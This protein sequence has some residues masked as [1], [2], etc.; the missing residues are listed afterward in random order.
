MNKNEIHARFECTREGRV[1]LTQQGHSPITV[2]IRDG[3]AVG[4]VVRRIDRPEHEYQCVMWEN[5]PALGIRLH[6][7]GDLHCRLTDVLVGQH[8]S[9]CTIVYSNGSIAL[10]EPHDAREVDSDP[11]ESPISDEQMHVLD[12]LVRAREVI[13]DDVLQLGY[14]SG[15]DAAMRAKNQADR[16]LL[17]ALQMVTRDARKRLR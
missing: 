15:P 6:V 17:D 8:H 4:L 3:W 14:Y 7:T 10:R 1:T 5:D 12:L 13:A 11:E 9:E 2:T 16:E